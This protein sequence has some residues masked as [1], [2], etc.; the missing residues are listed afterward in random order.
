MGDGLLQT[1]V[2]I[3]A[4]EENIHFGGFFI[5]KQTYFPRE[6]RRNDK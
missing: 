3:K 5:L 4:F 6:R 2:S 1:I